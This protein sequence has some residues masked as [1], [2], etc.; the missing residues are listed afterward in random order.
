LNPIIGNNRIEYNDQL[1][2]K[3]KEYLVKQIQS[4]HTVRNK[5]Q[6]VKRFYYVL[7]NENAQDLLSVSIETRQHAMKSLASLSKYLGIMISGRT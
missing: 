1:W 4:P 7:E 3:F 5:V 2:I 6:Y